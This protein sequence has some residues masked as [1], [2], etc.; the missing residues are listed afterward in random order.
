MS[1]TCNKMSAS[2]TSSSVLLKLSTRWCG[3]FLIKPTVSLRRNGVLSNTTFL[4]VVSSVANNLFSANTSLLLRIFII[5]LFPTLVYPTRATLINSPRSFLWINDCLSISD[6]FFFK[7]E[8][9]SLTI[10][11][12]VSIS[13]S[14]GPLVP[15]PPP[16]RS[17]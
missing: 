14:P 1:T 16:K 17:R 12:S 7:R 4:V 2:R 13:V 11:R 3:S 5:V 6:S 9:L 10:R 8:I 15:I